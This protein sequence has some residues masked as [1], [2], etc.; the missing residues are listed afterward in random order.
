MI[1]GFSSVNAASTNGV[2]FGGNYLYSCVG[3]EVCLVRET[4]PTLLEVFS[5]SIRELLSRRVKRQSRDND[6]RWQSEPLEPRLLLAADTGAEL[7]LAVDLRGQTGEELVQ[8]YAG[9]YLVRTQLL[10]TQFQRFELDIQ[11]AALEPKDIRVEFLNDLYV[12]GEIDR[13]VEVGSLLLNG[14]FIDPNNGPSFST[15]TWR[16][17]D[18][19]VSGPRR[20]NVLNANGYFQWGTPDGSRLTVY[21][22]GDEGGEQFSVLA[23]AYQF[24]T[25]T[26]TTELQA[27][28]FFLNEDV[29]A[30]SVQVQFLNDFYQPENGID[31]NLTVDRI[32]IDGVAYQA[33]A[34]EVFQSGVFRDGRLQSGFLL[35][36]TLQGNGVF[37]FN[38]SP[39]NSPR[40]AF[41]ETVSQDG[42][43]EFSNG[44]AIRGAS[45]SDG[46]FVGAT[47]AFGPSSSFDPS[48]EVY[49]AQGNVDTQFNGGQGVSLAAIVASALPESSSPP[50][51][52]V[53]DI[54]VDSQDRTLLPLN[55]I[56]SRSDGSF[57]S[58]RWVLRLTR[59]GDVDASFGNQGIFRFEGGLPERL[60]R[61]A[62][63]GLDRLVATDG[64]NL[65]RLNNVGQLDASFGE[66]GVASF[67]QPS[68]DGQSGQILT[69]AD[70]S[71]VV[72]LTRRFETTGDVGYVLQFNED[73]SP[74]EWFGDGGV[75]AIPRAGFSRSAFFG[76][77]YDDLTLDTEGRLYLTG[78]RSVLRL[79]ENGQVDNSYGARGLAILPDDILSDGR[80][81]QFGTESRAVIDSEGRAVL[82]S[83]F[84]FIRL[85]AFGQLDDS[86][87]QDGY[88][89]TYD[90]GE[91]RSFDISDLQ[92]DSSGR[93]FSPIRTTN[94]PAIAVWQLV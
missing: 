63:D 64:G 42:L 9:D 81:F 44:N 7:R 71:L 60:D 58:E 2:C 68:N 45:L 57:F 21:A 40:Y 84:G 25:A 19:I 22:R 46:S 24:P 3:V 50:G 70:Q 20:G 6:V 85:D 78:S 74:G 94:R 12:P 79:T 67:T 17:E 5:M 77:Q 62:V 61:F 29:D 38:N 59:N 28:E 36:E 37:Q 16:P 93:L 66:G 73:G 47:F 75:A 90:V 35:S 48:V 27:Y 86:F 13:N 89:A 39:Q 53:Q 88:A 34:P 72:W 56:G 30:G 41:D 10:S 54:L 80:L 1:H 15:G 32:E 4:A 8:I 83:G 69:R 43:I 55:V 92:I 82:A 65:V 31:F 49:D 11:N 14:L 33:E 87:S 76:E 23:G 18:G 52:Q 91:I 26:V 51:V